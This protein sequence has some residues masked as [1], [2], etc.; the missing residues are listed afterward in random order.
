MVPLVLPK[1]VFTD[2]LRFQHAPEISDCD[3]GFWIALFPTIVKSPNRVQSKRNIKFV[4]TL[5]F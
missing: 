5:Q 1:F 2:D 4:P 3:L